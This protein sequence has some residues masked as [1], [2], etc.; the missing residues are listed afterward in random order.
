[1]WEDEKSQPAVKPK[2]NIWAWNMRE[3]LS[4]VDSLFSASIKSW[5]QSEHEQE[6]APLVRGGKKCRR[7][8]FLFTRQ[9]TTQLW[10]Y[11]FCGLPVPDWIT[12]S[13]NILRYSWNIKKKKMV[14]R[15]GLGLISVWGIYVLKSQLSYRAKRSAFWRKKKTSCTNFPTRTFL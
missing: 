3:R 14:S 9:S 11:C 7:R 1:M 12:Y 8:L 6:I 15:E 4:A 13:L 2:S 5:C 10:E